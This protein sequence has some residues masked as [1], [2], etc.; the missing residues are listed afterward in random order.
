MEINSEFTKQS[1]PE[2]RSKNSQQ[3]ITPGKHHVVRG[4]RRKGISLK[5]L[6]RRT[7]GWLPREGD[8]SAEFYNLSRSQQGWRDL[9]EGKQ[10]GRQAKAW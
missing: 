2:L 3:I 5:S 8:V 1:R 9:R 6:G 4:V 7:Q 10:E